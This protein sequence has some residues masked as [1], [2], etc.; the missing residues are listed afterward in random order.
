MVK[1]QSDLT[2]RAYELLALPPSTP[3]LLIGD[4]GCGTGL[5]TDVL[6]EHGHHVV[7]LDIS[8]PMLEV[9][10]SREVGEDLISRDLGEGV[11]F[12]TGVFDAIISISALQWLCNADKSSQNPI[13]RLKLFFDTA[14]ASLRK[15]GRAVFQFY[16]ENATQIEMITTSAMKCGFTGGLVVDFP[17]STKAKKYF[18]ISFSFY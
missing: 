2:E 13:R 4:F 15:G 16:P 3:P 6:T 9:A 5:S 14:F 1:I 17:H 12:R 11:P 7:G 18:F 8:L 10:L